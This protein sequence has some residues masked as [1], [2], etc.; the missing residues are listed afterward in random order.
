[1]GINVEENRKFCLEQ[2]LI[3]KIR[4]AAKRD[5]RQKKNRRDNTGRDGP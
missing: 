3:L 5:L 2:L 1:M 4:R